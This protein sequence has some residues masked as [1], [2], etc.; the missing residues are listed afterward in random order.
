MTR[1]PLHALIA[2]AGI[3]G[4]TAALSLA[5]IGWRVTVLERS[6][7]VQEVGAG[8]QISPNASAILRDLGLLPALAET[9]LA[10]RAIHIRRGQD[11]AT[12][13]RLAL[14]E[15]E[16]RW[17]AP[18]LLVH[19]G[20]LQRTLLDAVA[21]EPEITL[22]TN[23]AVAGFATTDDGVALTALHGAI[24]FKYDGACLIGADGVRS[25]VRD[26]LGYDEAPVPDRAERVAFRA[27]V[28]PERVP[29]AMRLAESMLWLGRKAHVVHYPL[30]GGSV[31]NVVAVVDAPI[32]IDWKAEFW[33]QPAAATDVATQFSGF[34]PRVRELLAAT[35]KWL[36]W[37]LAER[38]ALAS[39]TKGPITLLGDAAHPMLPFL[40]QGAAQAIEDAAALARAVRAC[41]RVE[42]ALATY[43][44]IRLARARRVQMQSRRQALIYHLS[45]PAAYARDLTMRCL[46]A[47]R[48]LARYDW[49]YRP[50][51]QD[52]P[53]QA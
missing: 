7:T 8:L 46:G 23:S 9:S 33:S 18:Y 28:D 20:D 16:A 30:R 51:Q 4:L 3:G 1:K 27:L 41:D 21:N 32:K 42:L 44:K 50:S 53:A 14:E 22:V 11:G 29:A 39:W 52:L 19:R 31:I 6:K 35:D 24:R 10:P 12:L 47:E 45:G 34:D 38:P 13:A 26:R 40:A 49:I 17:G 15:A 36:R 25:F 5:R 48:L 2:G 43:E 37:P